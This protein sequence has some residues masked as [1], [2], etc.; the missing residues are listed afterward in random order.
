MEGKVSIIVPIYNVEKYLRQCINSILSQ[1]Y[2]SIEVILVDDGSPDSCPQ[3]CDQYASMHMN[4][5]VVHKQNGGLSS[6]RNAGLEVATG[7]Y[8]M[9]VDSDDFIDNNTVEY[10]LNAKEQSKADIVCCGINRYN[11]ATGTLLQNTVSKKEMEIMDQS[12]VL[13]R[14]VARTIDCSCC[15]KLYDRAKIGAQRFKVGRNNEDFLFLFDLYQN[16]DA[17]A[18]TNKAF[19]NYR[20]TSGSITRNLNEKSFDIFKNLDDV[21]KIIK[22]KKLPLSNEFDL[23]KIRT[24]IIYARII[25][26]EG[27]QKVFQERYKG[28]R[29]IVKRN[30][31]TIL[32][33]SYFPVKWK[34]MALCVIIK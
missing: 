9:F 5:I 3:I 8:V 17:V 19:Y 15:N 1:T 21:D 12:T 11:G 7:D 26:K 33:N 23:Y 24:N 4:V 2:K 18:Y 22:E 32:L 34:L 13:K 6:A 30:F 29:N 27:K 16:I 28:C 25:Q 20:I 10:L 14:L 31:L